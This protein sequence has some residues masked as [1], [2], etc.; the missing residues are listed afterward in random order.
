MVTCPQWQDALMEVE[1]SG[2]DFGNWSFSV[3]ASDAIVPS[4]RSYLFVGIVLMDGFQERGC[5]HSA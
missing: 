2:A 5:P 1:L 4:G 3:A